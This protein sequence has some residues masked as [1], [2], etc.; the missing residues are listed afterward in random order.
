MMAV[1]RLG[2]H[3]RRAQRARSGI[4]SK[5]SILELALDSRSGLRPDG[6]D[7]AQAIGA[8]GFN[9]ERRACSLSRAAGEGWGGGLS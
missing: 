1:E 3:S 8:C 9:I 5:T 6:N 2:C 7:T 4:Q